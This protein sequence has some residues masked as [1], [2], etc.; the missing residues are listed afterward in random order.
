MDW[1]ITIHTPE[2]TSRS[3]CHYEEKT[4]T[5]VCPYVSGEIVYYAYKEEKFLRKSR[6]VVR[7]SRVY[8]VWATNIFGVKLD[9]EWC[10]EQGRFDRLFKLEEDAIEF[11]VKKNQQQKIKIY[12]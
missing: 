12:K 1:Q 6:W 4:E 8:G 5:F 10:I 3:G 7:K 11:C 9:N 2:Y